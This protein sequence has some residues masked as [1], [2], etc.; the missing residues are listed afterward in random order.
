M[1]RGM[2]S[3]Q[4]VVVATLGPCKYDSP[5]RPARDGGFVSESARILMQYEV[6]DTK[7]FDGTVA[8]RKPVLAKLS[9]TRRP[10]RPPS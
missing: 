4:D 3:P 5:L 9:S 8:L 1:E 6:D 7:P 10:P 2:V